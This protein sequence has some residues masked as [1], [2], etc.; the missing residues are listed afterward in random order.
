[1]LK[2]SILLLIWDCMLY[3][4]INIFL[5]CIYVCDNYD[6][7]MDS[8]EYTKIAFATGIF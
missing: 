3:E 4:Y 6:A 1:M 5:L 7:V 8:L 2:M